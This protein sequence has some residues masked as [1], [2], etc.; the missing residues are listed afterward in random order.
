MDGTTYATHPAP[1]ISPPRAVGEARL[2]T[3]LDKGR[4]RI[5]TLRHG[6]SARLLFPRT[7]ARALDAVLLNTA[8]GVTGGDRFTISLEARAGT[9]LRL[10]TQAAERGYRAPAAA[11]PGRIDVRLT[12]E[13]GAMLAWLPQETIL[14]DGARVHRRIEA[15]LAPDGT[16]IAVEP[17]VF[18]RTA[19]GER[20]HSLAFRDHWRIRRAGTLVYAD[21]LRIEGDAEAILARRATLAGNR[22]MATLLCVAP[23]AEARLAPLRAGLPV[24]A[25]VMAGVMAGAS[26][27]RPG[28]L[29]ARIAAA[30]GFALRRV[31][32]PLLEGLCRGPLPKVWSL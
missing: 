16:L 31:L 28:V 4:S 12:A 11:A 15:D 21:A 14:F 1:T 10:A 22:A 26:L 7:V 23:D 2:S 32:V 27:I 9:H 20:L 19:R 29:A 30:D 25:G 24:T 5:A 3:R 8:G 6:G 13:P 18:G 17:L